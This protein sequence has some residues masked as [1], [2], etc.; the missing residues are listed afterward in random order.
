MRR[1]ES[2]AATVNPLSGMEQSPSFGGMDQFRRL[3][4]FVRPH[5]GRL[6]IALIAIVVGSVLSLAGPYTL[7]YLIDAVFRQND[8]ALLNRITLILIGIFATQSVFYFIRAYQLQF[9][10]ERVMA[11]L[12]LRLFEHLQGLS[13]SFFN[14]R[15]T[16]EL[17]SRL[18]ND[19]STVRG[20]VETAV[21]Q[22]VSID[23]Q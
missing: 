15:R 14:E 11:D 2:N 7:Q 12:R 9:I 5:R 1:R 23:Q 6:I 3:L 19:V 16:G 18:T 13:L 10:G 4:A 8:P 17:V 21:G 22:C 20:G